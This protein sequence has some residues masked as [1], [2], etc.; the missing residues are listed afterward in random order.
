MSDSKPDPLPDYAAE[1]PS[2]PYARVLETHTGQDYVDRVTHVFEDIGVKEWLEA[3][4]LSRLEL[5]RELR[6]DFGNL[7]NGMYSFIEKT[8]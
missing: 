8:I 2:T 4:P 3:N 5:T 6:S 7:V 1:I